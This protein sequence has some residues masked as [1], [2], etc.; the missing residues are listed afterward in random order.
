[1]G[2]TQLVNAAHE[3]FGLESLAGQYVGVYFSGHWVSE[4]DSQALRRESE[5]LLIT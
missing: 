3:N 4:E 1:M 2:T 5:A